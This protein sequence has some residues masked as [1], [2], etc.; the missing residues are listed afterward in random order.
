MTN[1]HANLDQIL[2]PLDGS[3][4]AASIVPYIERFAATTGA[5]VTLLG[6]AHSPPED[7]PI[8]PSSAADIGVITQYLEGMKRRLEENGI[9]ADVDVQEGE[10]SNVIE[11]C[12]S[13][14]RCGIIALSTR[15]RS[16]TGPNLLGITTDMLIRS[17]SVPIVVIPQEGNGGSV[18]PTGGVK[19]V[20]VGLDGSE[21][22]ASSLGMARQ[23]ARDFGLE[24]VLVRATPPV[25][26]LDGAATY[27]GS[28]SDHAEQYVKRVAD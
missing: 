12:A 14:R 7:L 9:S 16:A 27:F 2:L 1:S 24:M 19:T 22:A 3:E 17:S 10:A 11:A 23:F 8:D 15:G 18:S 28:V 20:I 4:A 13:G 5:E 21:T 6:V 25:D 26:S